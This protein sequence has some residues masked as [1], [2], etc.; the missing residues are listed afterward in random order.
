MRKWTEAEEKEI[1][2]AAEA[3]PDHIR[4]AFKELSQKWGN[5]RTSEAITT[6][7]YNVL[8]KRATPCPILKKRRES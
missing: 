2:K 8:L 6:R 1:L 7:Y 4:S 5:R 3:S